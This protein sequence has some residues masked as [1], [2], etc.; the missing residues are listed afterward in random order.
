MLH[1]MSTTSP[2][3]RSKKPPNFT[4]ADDSLPQKNTPT[5]PTK[6]PQQLPHH[7]LIPPVP[8]SH[9]LSLKHPAYVPPGNEP[10]PFNF[11]YSYNE[12]FRFQGYSGTASF[13]AWRFM[14]G[15]LLGLQIY[16]PIHLL[17]VI[18]FKRQKIREALSSRNFAEL[19]RIFAALLKNVVKS[20]LFISTLQTVFLA[21]LLGA[22]DLLKGVD[23]P[24]SVL[25]A[26]FLA[27]GSILFEKKP[28]RLEL[29]L[30]CVPRCVEIADRYLKFRGWFNWGETKERLFWMFMFSLSVG[31]MMALYVERGK[32]MKASMRG[33]IGVLIGE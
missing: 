11:P 22:R 14:S 17:P 23:H 16:L 31:G 32:R 33:L 9:D 26:G 8:T 25:L 28:R 1:T 3:T 6:L 12:I 4:H 29:G 19:R 20:C 5:E 27:G 13:L 18:L 24:V 10:H 15:M 2:T 21:G 30:Y 7:N